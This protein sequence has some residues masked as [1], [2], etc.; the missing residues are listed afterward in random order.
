MFE[1]D[2]FALHNYKIMTY[3][4]F[5]KYCV[6]FENFKIYSGLWPFSVCVHFTL[7]APD[8]RSNTSAAA[9]LAEFRRITTF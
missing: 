5:I 7:G 4:V 6:F 9:G 2:W 1:D 8:G 3:R